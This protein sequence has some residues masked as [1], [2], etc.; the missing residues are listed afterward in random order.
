MNLLSRFLNKV[1]FNSY[2]EM[3][4]ES[5]LVV[6]SN[7]NFAFDVVDEYA[8][9]CPEK[10]ALVWCNSAG[11]E[12]I[13]TFG[14]LSKLSNQTANYLLSLGLKKGDY[15]MTMLNRRWE[16][17]VIVVAC[18]KLGIIVIPATHLLTPKDVYFRC[19]SAE[20]KALIATN[21]LDVIEHITDALPQ[22]KTLKDVIYTTPVEGYACFDKEIEKFP[23]TLPTD[24]PK[25]I[26]TKYL[27]FKLANLRLLIS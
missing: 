21:E 11:E 1:D 22:C 4:A 6:P 19:N 25:I 7:F 20:A 9:L 2:E 17:W 5:Q 23:S 10:R 12:K 13:L 3:K 27:A 18:C 8:R 26:L 14:E 16:F 15:I 24:L